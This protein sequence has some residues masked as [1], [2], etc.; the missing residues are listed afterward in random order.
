MEMP[1]LLLQVE[2]GLNTA[3]K[4]NQQQQQC[5]GQIQQQRQQLEPATGEACSWQ[6]IPLRIQLLLRTVT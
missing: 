1:T 2:D 4:S 5:A 3:A 6:L